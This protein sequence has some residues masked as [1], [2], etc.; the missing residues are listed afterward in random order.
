[1]KKKKPRFLRRQW[2]MKSK[3]GRRRKKKQVWRK[4]KGRHIKTRLKYKGKSKQPSIGYRADRIERGKIHGRTPFIINNVRELNSIADKAKDYAIIVSGNTGAFKKID[5]AKRAI[6]LKINIINLSP[7]KFL[8]EIEERKVMKKEEKKTKEKAKEIEA[9]K[10]A[11]EPEKKPESEED[12][13]E[14][15]E[16]TKD[17]ILKKEIEHVPHEVAVPKKAQKDRPRRL[18]L[19]K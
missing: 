18:A 17:N 9:K 6:E 8:K 10:E 2:Y 16:E 12:K 1:M 11:K 19:E 4:P 15:I 3:L 7:E 14:K 13:K 5:I